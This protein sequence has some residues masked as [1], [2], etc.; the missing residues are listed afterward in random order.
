MTAAKFTRRRSWVDLRR[1]RLHPRPHPSRRCALGSP[2]ERTPS[3][4]TTLPSGDDLHAGARPAI[5]FGQDELLSAGTA[6]RS[7]SA[8]HHGDSEPAVRLERRVLDPGTELVERQHEP[9]AEAQGSVGP[10]DDRTFAVR[11]DEVAGLGQEHEDARRRYVNVER[12]GERHAPK[13]S[14]PRPVGVHPVSVTWLRLDA[15]R[16]PGGMPGE[17]LE[18]GPPGAAAAREDAKRCLLRPY[19]FRSIWAQVPR[20]V[21]FAPARGRPPGAPGRTNGSGAKCFDASRTRSR[22]ALRPRPSTTRAKRRVAATIGLREADG[23][24]R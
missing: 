12:R 16:T 7:A 21:R 2:D 19:R 10:F 5:E 17:R 15:V 22:P 23:D 3:Q 13:G 20:S 11:G 14:Q 6:E 24:D 9:G 8:Q 18:D 4:A 1:P